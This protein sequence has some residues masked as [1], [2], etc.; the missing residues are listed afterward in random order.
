MAAPP[1]ACRGKI[2]RWANCFQPSLSR[3]IWFLFNRPPDSKFSCPLTLLP[4]PSLLQSLS[5]ASFSP[6]TARI[7]GVNVSRKDQR[8][9]NPVHLDPLARNA[10]SD[11]RRRLLTPPA[12]AINVCKEVRLFTKLHAQTHPDSSLFPASKWRNVGPPSSLGI[13]RVSGIELQGVVPRLG[14]LILFRRRTILSHRSDLERCFRKWWITN[15][16]S[17]FSPLKTMETL[18]G[19]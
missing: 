17:K 11:P 7:K 19:V 13:R 3:P 12:R 1:D 18:S 10:I 16:K 4:L 8:S 15:C 6:C 9:F 2:G 14:I 5:T